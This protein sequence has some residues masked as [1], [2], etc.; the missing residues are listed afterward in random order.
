MTIEGVM[1]VLFAVFGLG[2]ALVAGVGL[3]MVAV[4]WLRK[5]VLAK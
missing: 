1:L 5:K 3:A 4:E 2:F